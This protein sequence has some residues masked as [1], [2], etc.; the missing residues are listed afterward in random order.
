MSH[1]TISFTAVVPLDSRA[2]D[3]MSLFRRFVDLIKD[4]QKARLTRGARPCLFFVFDFARSP[5]DAKLQTYCL[6]GVARSVRQH[7]LRCE[8]V[9]CGHPR[10]S[11]AFARCHARLH[12]SA[13]L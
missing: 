12:G 1:Y 7:A 3:F 4:N 13:C 9:N 5:T 6:A 10:R 2:L 11:Y 8:S